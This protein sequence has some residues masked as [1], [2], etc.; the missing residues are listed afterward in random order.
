MMKYHAFYM[1]HYD[2]IVLIFVSIEF[3]ITHHRS[4]RDTIRECTV[5]PHNGYLYKTV[6]VWVRQRPDENKVRRKNE[7]DL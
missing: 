6:F 5:E 3:S 4:V 7:N 1:R 2:K